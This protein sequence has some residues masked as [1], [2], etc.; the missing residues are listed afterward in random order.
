MSQTSPT[1][2]NRYDFVYLFDVAD[3][4]PNGDPDAGNQPR[5]DPET[6]EGLVTDVCLK[7]KVRNAVPLLGTG[8]G[9]RIYFQTQD[10]P[11]A[12]R[13]LNRLHQQAIDAVAPA[14][15][16]S[17]VAPAQAAT[18]APEPAAEEKKSGG[19]KKGGD[20]GGD[21]SGEVTAQARRWMCEQFW[22]V[23]AFGAVMTTGVNCGQ[24]R[25]P[26]QLTF[27]RSVGPILSLEHAITRKSVTT[28]EEAE[29]QLKEKGSITGTMG[30]KNT[31]PYGLYRCH[32]FVS[33]QLAAQTGFSEADL[34]LL[35][36][37]LLRMFEYDRSATRGQMSAR[38]LY[39][40]KHASALG[41]AP[42]HRLQALV[43]VKRNVEVARSFAAFTVSV[44]EAKLP[45]GVAL[46]VFDCGSFADTPTVL[47]A[48][49]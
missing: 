39:V 21:K 16:A 26:V 23:R 10:A 25:G 5:I 41:N 17:A 19:R 46:Q 43:D 2:T 7:R 9:H 33:P 8:T 47:S 29:T 13:V 24:V 11:D 40:F 28:Q 12:D 48:G 38:G 15:V 14:Q 22:D 37:S 36:Q 49:G 6:G 35:W 18:P 20:K 27:A 30:R 44:D 34:A 32:G 31:V 42:S 3:G 45:A 4:N 1:L